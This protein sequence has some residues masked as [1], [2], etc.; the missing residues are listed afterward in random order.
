[1]WKPHTQHTAQQGQHH[2]CSFNG[3]RQYS[4]E[5]KACHIV[6]V[7]LNLPGIPFGNTFVRARAAQQRLCFRNVSGFYC[8]CLRICGIGVHVHI[9]VSNPEYLFVGE[10]E[11]VKKKPK[12]NR[13]IA[14]LNLVLRRDG[15]ITDTL[16][17]GYWP[18]R[19]QIFFYWKV[20]QFFLIIF[21]LFSFYFSK[22]IY[23]KKRNH[24]TRCFVFNVTV[25]NY[26]K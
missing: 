17:C 5:Y 16:T 1:M 26:S 19:T 22:K 3:M 13:L 18:Y 21:S 11:N 6:S 15:C 25:A 20:P 10:G 12:T 24:N 14:Q 2:R 23:I 8:C 9:C 7:E 4:I